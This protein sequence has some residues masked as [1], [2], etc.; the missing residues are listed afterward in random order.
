MKPDCSNLFR[1]Q[2]ARMKMTSAFVA[3]SIV[4][5]AVAPAIAQEPDAQSLS[6]RQPGVRLLTSA[7]VGYAAMALVFG[8][9]LMISLRSSARGQQKP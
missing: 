6:P 2:T 5:L 3:L 4:C 7:W 8:L 1:F 9:I